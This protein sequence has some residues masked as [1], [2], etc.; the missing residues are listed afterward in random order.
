MIPLTT[1]STNKASEERCNSQCL[2]CTRGTRTAESTDTST[3]PD[4]IPGV[5]LVKI[6]KE[7]D[8]SK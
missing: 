3:A 7:L 4:K 5:F 1:S 2:G 6:L 8:T